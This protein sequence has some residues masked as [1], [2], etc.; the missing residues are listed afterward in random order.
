MPNNDDVRILIKAFREDG[1]KVHRKKDVFIYEGKIGIRASHYSATNYWTKEAKKVYYL[2]GKP[3]QMGYLLGFMAEKDIAKMTDQ[4]SDYLPFA[5]FGINASSTNFQKL[6]DRFLKFL[7]KRWA[8]GMQDDIPDEYEREMAGILDG[9]K[10]ANSATKVTKDDLWLLNVGFDAI[11]AH[12]YPGKLLGMGM[13]RKQT[14]KVPIMCNAFSVFRQA[15]DGKKNHY[16]ARDFMFPDAGI[17]QDT[18]CLIIYKPDSVNGNVIYPFVS[19]TAPGIV[20]TVAAMNSHGCAIGVDMSPT[21][22]CNRKHPGFNSLLL[23]RHAIQYGKSADEMVDII[24]DAPR[25]V[26]WLYAISDGGKDKAAIVETIRK[27]DFQSE[28]KLLDYLLSFPKRKYRN[29]LKNEPIVRQNIESY[30][31]KEREL[32]RRGVMVRWHDFQYFNESKF[33]QLNEKLVAE[34]NNGAFKLKQIDYQQFD[35]SETGF[36][37]KYYTQKNCPS[38]FFFAPQREKRDDLVL[39]TNSCISPEMRLLTMHSWTSLLADQDIN[40]IQWRYD[41]LNQLLLDAISEKGHVDYQTAREILDFMS[42]YGNYNRCYDDRQQRSPDFKE[43]AIGGS[44]S[45]FDLKNKT[46]ESH[47]GYYCDKWVKIS[48]RKYLGDEKK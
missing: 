45:L 7:V 10:A 47:F 40:D 8:R 12:L 5:F 39:V 31:K 18:A 16:F 9:C 1:F 21:A 38:A 26:S 19:Q 41:R 36:I 4:Y 14:V 20:G 48:L 3:Y 43:I 37:N 27:L 29:I 46:I 11:L 25:G 13:F 30:S 6:L 2:E 15:T 23:C 33:M 34:Y 28:G 44:M 32:L 22:A 35:Y 17:Y 42:P 24:A